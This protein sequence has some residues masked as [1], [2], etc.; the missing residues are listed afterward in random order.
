MS[1]I[2]ILDRGVQPK[3]DAITT[4][5]LIQEAINRMTSGDTLLIPNGTF[6]IA[7]QGIIPKKNTIVQLDG[8]LQQVTKPYEDGCRLIMLNAGVDSIIV[9][10]K[11]TLRGD[12]GSHVGDEDIPGAR[13]A[14]VEIREGASNIRLNGFSAIMSWADGI[15]FAPVP[16]DPRRP[17]N[18]VVDGVSCNDNRRNGLSIMD[19]DTIHIVNSQFRRNGKG[20]RPTPPYLGIDIECG[21][22]E[23]ACR[24]IIV[25]SNV[26]DNNGQTTHD[27][28]ISVGGALGKYDNIHILASNV[29]DWRYQPIIVTGTA[30][31]LG[32]SPQAAA[33]RAM[34]SW[35]DG[36]RYWGYKNE[37]SGP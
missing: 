35:W 12:R 1:V 19:G 9:Q 23:S 4:T 30:G 26:F 31:R 21:P 27:G 32:T 14:C 36:Y 25:E 22:A 8:T 5:G 29:Y 20:S 11:G 16:D 28:N 3:A 13:G 17:K 6:N 15:S 37:W 10:G 34:F 33:L 2:N 18:V 7:A 24:N